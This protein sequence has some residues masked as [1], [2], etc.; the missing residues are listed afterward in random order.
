MNINILKSGGY[1]WQ[2]SSS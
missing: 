1:G 2:P